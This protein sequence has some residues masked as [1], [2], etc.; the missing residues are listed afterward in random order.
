MLILVV[1]KN[2]QKNDLKILKTLKL[3]FLKGTLLHFWHGRQSDRN[4]VRREFI[5]VKHKFDPAVDL[6]RNETNGLLKL[7]KKGQRMEKDIGKYFSM[8]KED[9]NQ[10]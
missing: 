3:N 8:R 9:L 2:K 6:I 5:L 10:V 4:Y 7:S 1:Y